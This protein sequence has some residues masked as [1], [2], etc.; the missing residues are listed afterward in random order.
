M[1]LSLT[2]PPVAAITP[3]AIPS[4]LIVFW[5]LAYNVGLY[6]QL[7]GWVLCDGANGTPDVRNRMIR[8]VPAAP[9]GVVRT[10][11]GTADHFHATAFTTNSNAHDHTGST[12][13]QCQ[14]NHPGST[15]ANYT[16][17]HPGSAVV[18]CAWNHN[19]G[20]VQCCSD[21]NPTT[22]LSGAFRDWE[23]DITDHCHYVEHTGTGWYHNHGLGIAGDT[24]SHT[25]TVVQDDHT[26]TPQPASEAHQH[27]VSGNTATKVGLLPPYRDLNLI[28][29]L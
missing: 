28:M 4:K 5:G 11:G 19:H 18:A 7:T 17:N 27:G 9:G 15:L 25:P 24:H 12:M 13:S 16:H 10:T 8:G 26:H 3:V 20:Y 6:P 21:V 14:H 23:D 29:K 22:I 2:L 1:T